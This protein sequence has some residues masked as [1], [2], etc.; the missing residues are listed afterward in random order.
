MPIYVDPIVSTV[1][2]GVPVVSDA[3][4]VRAG[5]PEMDDCKILTRLKAFI[6][7]QGVSATLEHVFRNK[8]GQA[9]DL[10][11]WLG[12][13]VSESGSSSSSV[14]PAGTCKVRIKRW[15]VD[16]G[17]ST[18]NPIYDIYGEA[19]NAGKGIL[20]FTLEEEVVERSGIYEL[21]FAVID[22]NGRPIS[23]DRGIMSVERSMFALDMSLNRKQLGPPTLQEV[24]MRLMDSSRNENLLLD[25][26][27][28]KDEQIL[29]ALWEPIRFWNETPP[30]I[31]RF[32]THD[33]PFHGAWI[34]GVLGQLHMTMAN[35]YRRNVY[36]GATGGTNDKDK[37]REYLGEGQRLWEEYKAWVL[38]KKVECNLRKFAGQ[39]ISAYSTRSG[40]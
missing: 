39:A 20:R 13:G 15:G 9:V 8:N 19:Y 27:E 21:S 16:S 40:W 18:Q 38:N 35:H 11:E 24:R 4:V 3:C 26:I 37:E 33:F 28:F 25:D 34:I 22:E 36:R 6:V 30:P 32:S 17:S 7:D 5:I 2:T 1:D 10:T 14:T 29:Q 12:A 23:I 31:E